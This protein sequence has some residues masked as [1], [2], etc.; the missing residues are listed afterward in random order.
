MLYIHQTKLHLI[1]KL[2]SHVNMSLNKSRAIKKKH[3]V[4]Y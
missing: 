3:L 4:A 2:G 1:Y